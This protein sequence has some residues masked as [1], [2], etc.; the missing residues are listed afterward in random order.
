MSMELIKT[1]TYFLA[2]GFLVFLAITVTRDNFA[3]RL[4]RISGSMLFFAGLGPIFMALGAVIARSAPPGGIFEDTATYNLY[5]IWE[6]FFPFLLVFSWIFT[7]SR[8]S[9]TSACSS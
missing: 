7:V 1:L 8:V 6:L 3:N 2:G 9:N 4:N 5:Y